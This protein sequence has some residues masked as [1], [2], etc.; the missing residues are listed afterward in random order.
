MLQAL[1]PITVSC[2]PT[3]LSL[4]ANLK[5]VGKAEFFRIAANSS[6]AS[7]MQ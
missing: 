3:D 1:D 5:E 7:Q 4:P 6:D 2:K